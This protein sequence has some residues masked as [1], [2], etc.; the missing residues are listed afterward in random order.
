MHTHIHTALE[1]FGT[2]YNPGKWGAVGPELF[3]EAAR[4]VSNHTTYPI[5]MLKNYD[6]LPIHWSK[7]RGSTCFVPCADCSLPAPFLPP[8][9]PNIGIAA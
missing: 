7:V 1:M 6:F 8:T 9:K 2:R 4:F 3:T 5:E